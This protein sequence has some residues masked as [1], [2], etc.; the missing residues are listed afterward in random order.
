MLRRFILI[1]IKFNYAFSKTI[2]LL[3]S[4]TLILN[5]F[6]L[7]RFTVFLDW[8]WFWCSCMAVNNNVYVGSR[9]S[10]PWV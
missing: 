1:I 8:L 7:S 10:A 5:I 3:K 4:G 6:L 2:L 9:S